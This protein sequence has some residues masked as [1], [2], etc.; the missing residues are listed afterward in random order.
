MH[1]LVSLFIFRQKLTSVYVRVCI[2]NVLLSICKNANGCW[3]MFFPVSKVFTSTKS[4]RFWRK[5]FI[6]NSLGVTWKSVQ[7]ILRIVRL[8]VLFLRRKTILSCKNLRKAMLLVYDYVQ[9]YDSE[10]LKHSKMNDKNV[11]TS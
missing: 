1:Q 10:D 3:G 7:E 5:G 2:K 11:S 6:N 9:N 4:Y 8:T